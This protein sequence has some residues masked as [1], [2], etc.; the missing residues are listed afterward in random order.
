MRKTRYA[1][2]WLLACCTVFAHC[3]RKP[4]PK[5]YPIEGQILAVAPADKQL[6]IKHG[7][8]V[9]L[10]PGMTMTFPVSDAKLLEGRTP[11]ELVTGTL[12]VN[13]ALGRIV[14][15]THVGSAPLPAAN[16]GALAALMLNVG[17]EVPDAALID[18]TNTRRALSEWRGQFAVV[19]F[20]YTRCP[21]PTFCP[22]MDQSFR[23]LQGELAKDPV[24]RERVKLI[25]ITFDPVHDTPEVLAAHAKKLRADPA[26]WTM[27]TGDQVTVDR[28]AA[29]FGVTV[30][31]PA[32][33]PAQITHNLRTA[34]VGP[35]GRLTHVYSGN[36]WTPGAVLADLRAAARHP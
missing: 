13:D 29:R 19:T 25:S 7:D 18:Q 2:V 22:L 31:K 12:E 6:T 32:E 15:L 17:D 21:L 8:I 35:D 28:V 10:M 26:V 5:Q 4:A 30:F 23:T 9:G 34:I 14:A 36:E 24:L 11:G 16:D 1:L 27:L 33:D 3:S 20:I